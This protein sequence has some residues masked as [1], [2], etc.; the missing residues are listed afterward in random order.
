MLP[1][2]GTPAFNGQVQLGVVVASLLY[3]VVPLYL[4]FRLS[5]FLIGKLAAE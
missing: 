3:S 4:S 5:S 1:E 2:F